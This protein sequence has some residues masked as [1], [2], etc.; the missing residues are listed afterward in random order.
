M[1]AEQYSSFNY[2]TKYNNKLINKEQFIYGE[3]L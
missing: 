2:L 1:Q 3:M